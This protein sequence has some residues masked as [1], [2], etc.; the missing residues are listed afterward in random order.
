MEALFAYLLIGAIAGTIGGLLG[1]G[2]GIVVVPALVWMFHVH[3][4]PESSIMHLAV[5]TSLATIVP[6]SIASVRAHHKHGAVQWALISHL[7]P[8]FALG[9]L[10][11]AIAASYVTSGLLRLLFGAF[12]CLI[13]AQLI[14]ASSPKPKRDLP[15]RRSLI[16]IGTL[17]G[18]VSALLGIGG[19]NLTV[20]VLLRCRVSIRQAIATGAV[21]GIPIA[22]VGAIAY[23]I[24]GQGT[25]G[26]PAWSAGYVYGPALAGIAVMSVLFAAIGAKLTHRLPIAFC[27]A[28][29]GCSC[30]WSDYR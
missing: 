19:G 22:T 17:I 20:P 23:V 3:G 27:G 26:L 24:S 11:G 9:A 6:T 25:D 29:L 5:G 4:V 13:A 2:G 7:A 10:I 16:I 12:L 28:A 14:L 1:I 30:S 21:A 15:G 8:G 18:A